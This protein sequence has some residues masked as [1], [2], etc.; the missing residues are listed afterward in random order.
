MKID[1]WE[2]IDA[3][4]TKPFGFMRFE[5]GPGMGG[6]CLPVDPFYL[7]WK[8]R[9]YDIATEFI[10]L[11][12][13]VNQ[14]MPYFCLERAERALNDAGKPVK[15]SKI[16]VLGVAYKAGV[17]DMRESP[18]LKILRLL[19]E[20]G[21]DVSYHDPYVPELP[22]HGLK[23]VELDAGRGGRRPRGDR[24]RAP[25]DRPRRDRARG[26]LHAGPARHHP[27]RRQ[28]PRPPALTRVLA[29][30]NRYPPDGGG[31]YE[32]IFASTVEALVAR[33]HDVAVPDDGAGATPNVEGV[34]PIV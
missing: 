9:E 15:G 8:A 17:S 3:A 24:D 16:L 28:Q 31:G 22:S 5:P 19:A 26:R 10:E 20:R 12:G 13:K 32:R 25:G 21:G 2:V 27:R 33:G 30:G 1:V 4:S 14:H 23:S 7:T 11:A 6:H 18:A 29:I 34:T